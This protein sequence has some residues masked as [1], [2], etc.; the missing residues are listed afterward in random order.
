MRTGL[1]SL[2]YAAV[3][4][5]S[6]PGCDSTIDFQRLQFDPN[7]ESDQLTAEYICECGTDFEIN[8]NDRDEI[9]QA[10]FK[11]AGEEI[12]EAKTQR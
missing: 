9:I 5:K 11:Q 7:S 1:V 8:I 4:G 12:S 10:V 2:G 3:E 6:C